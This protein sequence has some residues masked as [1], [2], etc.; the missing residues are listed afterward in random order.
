MNPMLCRTAYAAEKLNQG[1]PEVLAKH[2]AKAIFS[3][4]QTLS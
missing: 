2:T 1:V 4:P 3:P